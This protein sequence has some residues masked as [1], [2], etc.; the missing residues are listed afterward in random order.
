VPTKPTHLPK[1]QRRAKYSS[2]AKYGDYREEIREDSQRRCVYCDMHE[3][4]AGGEKCM[5]LDHYRPAGRKHEPTNLVW[6]CQ[7]CNS[8]KGDRWPAFGLP[9]DPT[10]NGRSGFI[11]PFKEDRRAYFELQDDGSFKA[12]K[13]PAEYM[14]LYLELNRPFLMFVRR[15]R[16]LIYEALVVLEGYIEDEIAN[17]N[18][19]L[20]DPRL[21]ALEKARWIEDRK[22]V[23]VLLEVVEGLDEAFRLS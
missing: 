15:R 16:D 8:L 4:E 5:T 1:L 10:V 11:D 3:S 22:R 18:K 14:I 13:D 2:F 23:E 20:E 9:G 7:P 17:F 12:I 6:A 21:S 19:V